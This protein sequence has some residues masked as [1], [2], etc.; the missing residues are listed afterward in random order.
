MSDRI[1][2]VV[3]AGSGIGLA[4][5]KRFGREG[6]RL[7]LLAR[8]AETLAEYVTDL[9]EQGIDAEGFPADAADFE[10]LTTALAEV[11]AQ[12]GVPEVLV[13]NPAVIRQQKPS[14]LQADTLLADLRVN[15]AGALVCAQQV[16]PAMTAKGR[17]TILF[18]GGGLALNPHPQYA[19]LAVGKAALRNL[20]YSLGAELEAAGI[21]VATVTIAGF[22]Q[23]GTF[24]DPD[25][26][27]E[28]YWAL[29]A[30]EAG[31]WER[32]VVY[33]Q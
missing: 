21:H 29:H 27:A 1:C 2:A 25:L 18:T 31:R 14:A 11:T 13:Y 16:I 5:A 7:A 26:I 8:R 32:E 24:F 22:V 33:A 4:V 12:M 15:V 28:K 17:G 20:T 19:S 9:G 10:S 6:F 23:P 3:G 30:Q